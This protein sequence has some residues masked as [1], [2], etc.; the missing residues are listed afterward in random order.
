MYH[1]VV[2]IAGYEHIDSVCRINE[3]VFGSKLPLDFRKNFFVEIIEDVEQVILIIKNGKNL[4]GY[5]H[6]RHQM[7]LRD[8]YYVDIA[9]IAISPY[10]RK[11]GGGTELIFGVEQWSRQTLYEL[12]KCSFHSENIAMKALLEGC[13]YSK[14]RFGEF[15]KTII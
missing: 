6:A 7:S 9:E 3:A 10:Y 11:Q 2:E 4:A 1:F 5:L 8:G 12:L 15:E 13:G 14:N